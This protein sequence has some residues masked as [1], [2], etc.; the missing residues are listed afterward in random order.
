MN[1]SAA[2]ANIASD[3]RSRIHLSGVNEVEGSQ[4]LTLLGEISRANDLVSSLMRIRDAI[5]AI[6]VCITGEFRPC[7]MKDSPDSAAP[8]LNELAHHITA[9]EEIT[10]EIFANIH[11]LRRAIGTAD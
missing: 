10:G 4:Q 11:M 9:A 7:V 6:T 1:D 5:S 3:T 2:V 8:A